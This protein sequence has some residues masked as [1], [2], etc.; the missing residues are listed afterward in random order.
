MPAWLQF[1]NWWINTAPF[2]LQQSMSKGRCN[3]AN[4]IAYFYITLIYMKI[5]V[6]NFCLQRCILS[7]MMAVKKSSNCLLARLWKTMWTDMY[8]LVLVLLFDGK[9]ADAHCCNYIYWECCHTIGPC[10]FGPPL[11]VCGK[12]TCQWMGDGTL[13]W[14]IPS[15]PCHDPI[16]SAGIPFPPL[17]KYPETVL[18]TLNPEANLSQCSLKDNTGF[19]RG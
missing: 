14:I 17:V 3:F 10:N 2:C 7:D 16:T 11:D 15:D 13:Y 1:F 8:L 6:S 18:K 4:W 19:L 9:G 5:Y 12:R